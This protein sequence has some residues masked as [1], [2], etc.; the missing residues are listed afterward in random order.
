MKEHQQHTA[1][2]CCCEGLGMEND[3]EL[4][5]DDGKRLKVIGLEKSRTH[6]YRI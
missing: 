2:R 3:T 5:F 4:L 6:N 1:A